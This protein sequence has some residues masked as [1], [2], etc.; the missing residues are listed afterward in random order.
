MGMYGGGDEGK[1]F[2]KKSDICRR[3]KE[4]PLHR[5]LATVSA[6]EISRR[7]PWSKASPTTPFSARDIAIH[8]TGSPI[9]FSRARDLL[10]WERR[11]SFVAARVPSSRS[12]LRTT[13]PTDSG[14]TSVASPLPTN[15]Q[16]QALSSPYSHHRSYNWKQNSKPPL[17]KPLSLLPCF[18]FQSWSPY[19]LFFTDLD[20]ILYGISA[21]E[22]GNE[23]MFCLRCCLI[24]F[25]WL[26]IRRMM[27]NED[28]EYKLCCRKGEGSSRD[29]LFSG[30]AGDSKV[31]EDPMVLIL[32]MREVFFGES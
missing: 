7:E 11:R 27:E 19:R 13:I 30:V 18:A 1:V 29:C 3:G 17:T 16:H 25:P 26:L 21:W 24:F 5:L 31:D 20:L 22:K 23:G 4:N 28:G 10:V 12:L 15:Q 9:S 2:V 6:T 14:H 32:M 8:R